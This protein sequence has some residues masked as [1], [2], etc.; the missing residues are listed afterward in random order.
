MRAHPML[1]SLSFLLLAACAKDVATGLR[2]ASTARA[3]Q[4]GATEVPIH[5]RCEVSFR[6]APPPLLTPPL[7]R[8]LDTGTC[9]FSHLGATGFDGVQVIDF[10]AGTQSGERTLTAA[11]GDVLRLTHTG[12]SAPGVVPGTIDFVANATVAGGTGRFA[13]ATGQ[14]RGVGTATFATQTSVVTFDGWI[15]YDASD[16]SDR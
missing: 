13:H 5:G 8:Q 16:R 9:V 7:V 10:A 14:L 11:N 15:T 3:A 1:T 12:T 2:P 6:P 4:R